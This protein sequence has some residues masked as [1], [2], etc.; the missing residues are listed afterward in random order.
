MRPASVYSLSLEESDPE[1]VVHTHVRTT[2]SQCPLSAARASSSSACTVRTADGESGSRS[3]GH[4]HRRRLCRARGDQD[5]DGVFFLGG[6][7]LF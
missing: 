6:G 5:G 3:L 2:W 1:L 4:H 7:I